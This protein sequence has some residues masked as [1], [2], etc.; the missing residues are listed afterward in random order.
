MD[1]VAI[2]EVL[3]IHLHEG[4][5]W[6]GAEDVHNFLLSIYLFCFR[7]GTMFFLSTC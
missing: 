4:L 2:I 7:K 3:G 6:R 1:Y 5:P